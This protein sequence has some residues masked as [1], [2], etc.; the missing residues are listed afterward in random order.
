MAMSR[1]P[2]H[3]EQLR[4]A[5]P[6]PAIWSD[7]TGDDTVRHCDL[8]R[9]NVYNL[10]AMSRAEAERLVNEREGRMCAS[11]YRRA[12]GTILTQD[13]PMGLRRARRKVVGLLVAGAAVILL[14]A[15]TVGLL[16]H[17]RDAADRNLRARNLQ[18]IRP[19]VEWLDPPYCSPETSELLH[20]VGY[21]GPPHMDEEG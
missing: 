19:V 3:L 2:V 20:L 11:F 13:C 16:T 4:V 21:I 9:R 18:P 8:C 15:E 12:D 7:M 17:S 5:S 6:C 1:F 10:S 14:A